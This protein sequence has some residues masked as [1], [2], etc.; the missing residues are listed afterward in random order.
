MD[1]D[2]IWFQG[3]K[4][5]G[6]IFKVRGSETT[7]K[8]T[9]KLSENESFFEGYETKAWGVYCDARGVFFCSD[10]DDPTQEAALKL[11]L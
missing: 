4:W 10:K 1:S 8:I 7:W 2:I 9:S 5:I 11:R 6:K 3:S